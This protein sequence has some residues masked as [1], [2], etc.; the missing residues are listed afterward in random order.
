MP[1]RLKYID[2]CTEGMQPVSLYF[3]NIWIF[4]NVSKRFS[5]WPIWKLKFATEFISMQYAILN[6][7]AQ[8][9]KKIHDCNNL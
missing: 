8:S 7:D 6:E 5:Y 2:L 9:T 4:Q 1:K 3:G